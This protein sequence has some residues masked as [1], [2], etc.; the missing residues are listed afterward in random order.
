MYK[1]LTGDA[2][3]SE[4]ESHGKAP[5]IQYRIQAAGGAVT[6]SRGQASE[7]LE[8][9]RIRPVDIFNH[10]EDGCHF[11]GSRNKRGNCFA[12]LLNAGRLLHG[13]VDCFQFKWL[14]QAQ[15]IIE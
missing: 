7:K 1:E 14:R 12:H 10:S 8:D 2:G 13:T 11:A 15:Q 9:H 5:H 3:L 6:H 4:D